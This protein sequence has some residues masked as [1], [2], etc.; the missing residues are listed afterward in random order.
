MT[1]LADFKV[2]LE[3]ARPNP[4]NNTQVLLG[5]SPRTAFT[6][7]NDMIDALHALVNHVG[8]LAPS[9]T[10]AWMTWLDTSVSPPTHKQ[11]NYNNTA[12]VPSS[13]PLLGSG[14]SVTQLINKTTGVTLNKR[15]GRIVM[16]GAALVSNEV[17]SFTF[18]NSTIT[19]YDVV[20]VAIAS[21]NTP[22]GYLI[23]AD[24][25]TNGTCRINLK[26]ISAGSLSDALALNFVV[27]RGSVT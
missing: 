20:D 13:D 25:I 27:H 4:F 26:N 16:S 14:G 1:D 23:S 11:R 21:S 19:Q 24:A 9:P 6:K 7:Y 12:W 10:V 5:D 15:M 3:T 22:L 17:A 18:T 8:P 2:D